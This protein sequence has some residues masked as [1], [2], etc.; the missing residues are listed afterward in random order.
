MGTPLIRSVIDMR[1]DCV[2][3][4]LQAGATPDMGDSSGYTALY[5]AA[6]GIRAFRKLGFGPNG[7]DTRMTEIARLLIMRGADPDLSNNQGE[8]PR[9]MAGEVI[10]L[11]IEEQD[12]RLREY[13]SLSAFFGGL[14]PASVGLAGSLLTDWEVTEV[15]RDEAG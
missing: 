15:T 11:L 14:V 13:L 3:A 7:G 5:N 10:R 1:V 2:R 12:Q 6:H 8:S 9:D 4:L